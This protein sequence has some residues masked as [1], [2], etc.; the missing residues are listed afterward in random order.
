[1]FI[2]LAAASVKGDIDRVRILMLAGSRRHLRRS[3][4]SEGHIYEL[5]V[6]RFQWEEA[7]MVC[8]R[9]VWSERTRVVQ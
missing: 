2:L 9:C 7:Y 6:S 8:S 3:V 5:A 1:M 4:W